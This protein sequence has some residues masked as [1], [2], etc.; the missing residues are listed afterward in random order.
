MA[1]TKEFKEKFLQILRINMGNIKA[2]LEIPEFKGLSRSQVYEWRD[3]EQWFRE[4]LFDI[5]E[6]WLDMIESS[7]YKTGLEGNVAA[8]IF[9]L[10]TQ[11]KHRGYVERLEIDQNKTDEFG[12]KTVEEKLKIIDDWR[13]KQKRLKKHGKRS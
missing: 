4:A 1:Y 9:F 8:Q 6:G 3:R 7:L 2:T 10:K 12:E 5:K 11:G 13:A